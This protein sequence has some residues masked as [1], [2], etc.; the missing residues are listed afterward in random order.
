MKRCTLLNTMLLIG[1]LCL[2]ACRRDGPVDSDKRCEGGAASHQEQ[3]EIPA[4]VLT[5]PLTMGLN[6]VDIEALPSLLPHRGE[7][8]VLLSNDPFLQPIPD[9]IRAELDATVGRGEGELRRR[10]GRV[11]DPLLMPGMLTS[12][13]L[14][15]RIF[16]RIVW[17]IPSLEQQEQVNLEKFQELLHLTGRSEAARSFHKMANGT[18]NGEISGTPFEVVHPGA[19]PMLTES[20]VLHIDLGYFSPIYKNEIK[21]PL[22]PL[23]GETLIRLR[24]SKWPIKAASFSYSNHSGQIALRTRPLGVFIRSLFADPQLLDQ[25]KMPEIWG[26]WGETLYLESFFQ[27]EEI[28]QILARMAAEEPDTPWIKYL[29]ANFH[30]RTKDEAN[31]ERYLAEAVKGDVGYA[32]EYMELAE[33]ARGQK[34]PELILKNL[35]K[36][37]EAMP[38]DPLFG[39][40][41]CEELFFQGEYEE[42]RAMLPRLRALNWSSHYYPQVGSILESFQKGSAETAP[43]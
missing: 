28:Q 15:Q 30:F 26:M 17:V 37:V 42:V 24:G 16:R 4:P 2:F 41:L 1:L 14:E 8:L 27:N 32:L 38:D 34:K 7:T 33:A 6:E 5:Q 9:G 29:Q 18:L 43:H 21:T 35:R 19:L 40:S 39:L 31:A 3:R 13:M 23:V 36:L 12:A 25:K 20:V 22:L 11:A 10:L